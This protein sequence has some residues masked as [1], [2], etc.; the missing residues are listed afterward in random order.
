MHTRTVGAKPCTLASKSNAMIKIERD[1]QVIV[2]VF[3]AVLYLI[4]V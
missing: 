2:Y 3:S 4:V 1:P